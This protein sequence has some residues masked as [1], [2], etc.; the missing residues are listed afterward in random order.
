[1]PVWSGRRWRR[2]KVCSFQYS[3][4]DALRRLRREGRIKITND[5]QYSIRDAVTAAVAP[6]PG[7]SCFQYSIRDAWATPGRS[8]TAS[9]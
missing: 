5:F 9:R 8:P 2:T 3:I 6:P 1:M 4:R 7:G